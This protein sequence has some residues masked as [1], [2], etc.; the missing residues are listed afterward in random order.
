MYMYVYMYV[1]ICIC[2]CVYIYIYIY[3]H[4]CRLSAPRSGICVDAYITCVHAFGRIGKHVCMVSFLRAISACF[5]LRLTLLRLV[6]VFYSAT[7]NG[8]SVCTAACEPLGMHLDRKPNNARLDP[9]GGI[10]QAPRKP[11]KICRTNDRFDK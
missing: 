4:I 3:I 6:V 11:S 7:W 8:L 5:M 10:S 9:S 2:M 1:C